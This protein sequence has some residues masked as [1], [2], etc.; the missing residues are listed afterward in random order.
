MAGAVLQTSG[1]QDKTPAPT[2]RPPHPSLRPRPVTPAPDTIPPPAPFQPL[3]LTAEFD[4][5]LDRFESGDHLFL[6]GR[7][8]TGKS[9]LLRLLR[10]TT[11]RK[12]A[13][14]APTGVAALNV[15]GQT[16][17]SF[18]SWP[19]KLLRPTDVKRSRKKR[20][21]ERLDTLVID[22]VSMVRADLLDRVDEFLRL[23]RDAPDEPFGGVQVM[24]IGDLFQL[25]P[26]VASTG[27]R[28]LFEGEH[29]QYPSPHFF[30][31]HVWRE[32]EL[33]MIELNRVFR[34]KAR[35]FVRL[36]D[37]VREG[38]FD[39]DDLEDLNRRVVSE[40]EY[41]DA[42]AIT[43]T[44]T[45]RLADAI[46]Q[47]ALAQL[48]A[49]PQRYVGTLS[50]NFDTRNLPTD[51]ALALKPGAQ[52]MFVRNDPEKRFV[53]GSIGQVLE[54]DAERVVVRLEEDGKVRDV[55]VQQETWENIRYGLDERTGAIIE[56]VT[57]SFQQYPL[58][59]AWAI[60]IHKSQGKT[61]ERMQLDLGR[62][63]FEH[64]QT[65]VAL[66]RCRTLDGIR[67]V[68][69]LRERDILVDERVGDWYNSRR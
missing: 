57:G 3:E 33:E 7:A 50:G 1:L 45:N 42:P 38:H 16:L 4:Y 21:Y 11:R 61:F 58:K 9:T 68:R 14:L 60:T 69:P 56:D 47:R 48:T 17:H 49:P 43:L 29:A 40:A 36:L 64:G 54:T 13:V 18:F 28:S 37:A 46:N 27:E 10:A 52:V 53:N 59:L 62:G 20:L 8:G 51:L 5:A 30:D 67:L 31:A 34:Q 26:V 44:A 32:T 55:E 12:L 24:L 23:N 25:P 63:A 65:Y 15:R 22:E 19:G 41:G 2:T 39:E 6:T 35:Q 66:S